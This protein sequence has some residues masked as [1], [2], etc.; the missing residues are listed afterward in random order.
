MPILF[1]FAKIEGGRCYG[2]SLKLV[3]G[4]LDL[5]G[6]ANCLARG[7]AHCKD[8]PSLEYDIQAH[9]ERHSSSCQ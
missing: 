3:E 4:H 8:Q 1:E 9:C 6:E 5:K 7:I 2:V